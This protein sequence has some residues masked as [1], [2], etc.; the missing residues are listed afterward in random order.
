MWD[1]LS[2]NTSHL[3]E[4]VKRLL[5]H[6]MSHGRRQ[7]VEVAENFPEEC[8]YVLETLGGIWHHDALARE[9]ELSPE[10][11][12]RF[13][14]EHSG[15]LM[16]TLHDWM[17]TQLAERKTEPNSGL[18]KAIRYMLRHWM[19]LTLFLREPGAPIDNNIVERILK[20]A[21]LHRK[22][23]LFYKTLNGARVGDLFMSLIHTC[24]LNG[25]QSLR[26]PHRV[27]AA[28]AR[29]RS[30]SF[31]VDALELPPDAGPAGHIGSRIIGILTGHNH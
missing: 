25:V 28:R 20:K 15:P 16:K 9:Q 12:L 30:E 26:L 13:H 6:C 24:E 11:R 2:W 10:E 14:R 21:I 23:S 27:A 1:A 3:P 8:R 4:G 31:R 5:A 22:H 7:F 29:T 18:G 17:E 19:P